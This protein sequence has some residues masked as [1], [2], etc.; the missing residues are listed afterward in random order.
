[1]T[2]AP[3]VSDSRVIAWK[4]ANAFVPDAEMS[5]GAKRFFLLAAVRVWIGYANEWAAYGSPVP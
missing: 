2:A 3:Q 4:Y 5:A 1:M